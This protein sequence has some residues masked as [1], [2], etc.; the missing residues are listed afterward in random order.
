M[1]KTATRTRTVR[2]TTTPVRVRPVRRKS[3]LKMKLSELIVEAVN[4]MR[5]VRKDP[6]YVLA[7]EVWHEP[8]VRDFK[9][10]AVCMAG[11]I[12]AARHMINPRKE[13]QPDEFRNGKYLG[14]LYAV[15]NARLGRIGMA[16]AD[17]DTY[18]DGLKFGQQGAVGQADRLIRYHYDGRKSRAPNRIYLRAA[19][20]LAKVGL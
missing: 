3:L 13:V 19:K 6:K 7:M 8:R 5:Q 1:T 20:I 11:S 14:P 17:L 12:I 2:R 16:L 9:K 10:C 4:D 18:T 15:N